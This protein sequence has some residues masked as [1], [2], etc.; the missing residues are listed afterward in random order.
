MLSLRFSRQD[1][2]LAAAEAELLQADMAAHEELCRAELA[3]GA[4]QDIACELSLAREELEV[5]RKRWQAATA[6]ELRNQRKLA[7]T[8]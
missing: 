3:E 6:K 2:E 4:R 7:A 5:E 1:A 8:A